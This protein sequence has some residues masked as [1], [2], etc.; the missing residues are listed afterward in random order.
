M[1]LHDRLSTIEVELLLPQEDG[2]D[3]DL[4][5]KSDLDDASMDIIVNMIQKHKMNKD[6]NKNDRLESNIEKGVQALQKS[7]LTRALEFFEQALKID[8]MHPQTN[9][10]LAIINYEMGMF[11]KSEYFYKVAQQRDPNIVKQFHRYIAFH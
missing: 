10:Y 9:I 11:D 6:N 4:N 5:S 1:D 3:L 7:N 8:N 2:E